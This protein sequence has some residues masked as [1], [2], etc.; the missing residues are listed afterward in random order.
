VATAV[1][2]SDN[3]HRSPLKPSLAL[4]KTSALTSSAIHWVMTA[5]Y[6]LCQ[7]T[8]IHHLLRSFGG[9]RKRGRGRARNIE[10]RGMRTSE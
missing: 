3:G 7:Q 6:I 4:S 8:W 2:T 1:T 10:E 9:G 5:H